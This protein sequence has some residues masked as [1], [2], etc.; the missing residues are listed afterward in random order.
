MSIV[1]LRNLRTAPHCT[2]RE[3]RSSSA[4]LNADDVNKRRVWTWCAHVRTS[5]KAETRASPSWWRLTPTFDGV[6]KIVYYTSSSTPRR[7]KFPHQKGQVIAL[8][9]ISF[10]IITLKRPY[11]PRTYRL[12]LEVTASENVSSVTASSLPFGKPAIK[13]ISLGE[14]TNKNVNKSK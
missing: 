4:W 10:S 11:Q 6:L 9:F 5:L 3:R 1:H 7:G 13:V 2:I 14:R 12:A 8:D